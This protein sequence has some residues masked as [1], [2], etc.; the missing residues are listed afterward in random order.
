[1]TW[2]FDENINKQAV[3]IFI[4]SHFKIKHLAYDFNKSGIDDKEVLQFAIK[5][6]KTLITGDYSDFKRF[7]NSLIRK[8]Y[9]I[10]IFQTKDYKKQ[11]ELFKKACKIS[12]LKNLKDRKGKKVVVH[13]DYVEIEDCR[14][15]KIEK[16][17]FPKKLKT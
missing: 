11:L 4:K 3:E 12:S 14:T 6:K 17:S 1:M 9:G 10:W 16:T 8:S 13:E 2:L 5:N 7:P 15:E